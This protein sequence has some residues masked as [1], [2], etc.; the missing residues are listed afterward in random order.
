MWETSENPAIDTVNSTLSSDV[1][2]LGMSNHPN[3]RLEWQGKKRRAITSLVRRITV[4]N[5]RLELTGFATHA[6]RAV[7]IMRYPSKTC[8]TRASM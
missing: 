8:A 6:L 5:T 3:H 4:A 7:P 2:P 1:R